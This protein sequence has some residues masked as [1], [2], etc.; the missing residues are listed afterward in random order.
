MN[1]KLT[2]SDLK[3]I[4]DWAGSEKERL[5]TFTRNFLSR[6]FHD[7][8]DMRER[9]KMREKIYPVLEPF[10]KEASYWDNVSLETK[11]LLTDRIKKIYPI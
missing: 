6:S 2:I 11:K 4:I 5:D 3:A 10:F 1:N 7:V 9:K 8:N